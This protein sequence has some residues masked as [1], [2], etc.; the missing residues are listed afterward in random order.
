MLSCSICN[1]RVWNALSPL[2]LLPGL[3]SLIPVVTPLVTPPSPRL[4]SLLLW[5]GGRGACA[6]LGA[7]SWALFTKEPVLPRGLKLFGRTSSDIDLAPFL[8]EV[9]LFQTKTGRRSYLYGN[10]KLMNSQKCY[11]LD[12]LFRPKG[13]GVRNSSIFC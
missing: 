9:G 2:A 10:N 5:G 8:P 11:S 3:S 6:H 13:M 7:V 12:S 1:G 4:Q